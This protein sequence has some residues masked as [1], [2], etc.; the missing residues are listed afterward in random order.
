MLYSLVLEL[1]LRKKHYRPKER[2][3]IPYSID[4]INLDSSVE[5]MVHFAYCSTSG[6]TA[7]KTVT[8]NGF[9]KING[10][11]VAIYFANNHTASSITLNVNNTGAS[12]IRAKVGSSTVL[13]SGRGLQSGRVYQFIYYN[14][15]YYLLN[16]NIIDGYD[17][18]YGPSTNNSSFKWLISSISSGRPTFSSDKILLSPGL[19]SFSTTGYSTLGS[20]IYVKGYTPVNKDIASQSNASTSTKYSVIDCDTGSSTGVSQYRCTGSNYTALFENVIFNYMTVN[21]V[22]SSDSELFDFGNYNCK[23]K[24]KNCQFNFNT[25]RLMTIVSGSLEFENC[26][27]YFD[28]GD[29]DTVCARIVDHISSSMSYPLNISFKNCKIDSSIQLDVYLF[30]IQGYSTDHDSTY[31]IQDCDITN[32]AVFEVDSIE[33]TNYMRHIHI[34]NN[35]INRIYEIGK[36]VQSYTGGDFIF[37]GNTVTTNNTDP[38]NINITTPST[39]I[40][41]NIFYDDVYVNYKQEETNQNIFSNNIVQGLCSLKGAG[42]F[43]SNLT[44]VSSLTAVGNS[45]SDISSSGFGKTNQAYND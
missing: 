36:S 2:L 15:Y 33:N 43:H 31:I 20:N 18:I 14:S 42:A 30:T 11:K 45:C 8:V 41:N 32:T 21:G 44:S 27:F 38:V 16:P 4:G 37:Q 25:Y 9:T 28:R 7:A 35:N 34:I 19:Y 6:S 39:V 24:F 17:I 1:I 5:D 13:I 22:I 3:D 40:S 26:S 12:S 23:V 29:T 10:S